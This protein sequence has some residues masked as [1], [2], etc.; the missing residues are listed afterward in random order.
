MGFIGIIICGL[1]I[2]V[3]TRGEYTASGLGQF[4]YSLGGLVLAIPGVW[5]ALFAW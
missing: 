1:A 4:A 5:L 2:Y 3:G